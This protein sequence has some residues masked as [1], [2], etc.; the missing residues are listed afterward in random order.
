MKKLDEQNAKYIIRHLQ[1]NFGMSLSHDKELS[2]ISRILLVQ[3]NNSNEIM[4]PLY[5]WLNK[6]QFPLARHIHNHC[7]QAEVFFD[8]LFQEEANS[9]ESLYSYISENIKDKPHKILFPVHIN[10]AFQGLILFEKIDDKAWS[11]EEFSFLDA[12]CLVVANHVSSFEKLNLHAQSTVVLD[13]IMNQMHTSLYVTD[14]ETD[15]I[16]YMNKTMKEDFKLENPEGKVCWKI[17]QSGLNSRCESCPKHI[18]LTSN[19]PHPVHV[20]EEYNEVTK[21]TY[22][23]YDSLTQWTDGRIVH[24]QHSVDISEAKRLTHQVNFDSLT[25]AYSRRKGKEL[26]ADLLLQSKNENFSFCLCMIDVNDLK[27][28]NDT[29]GHLQGDHLLTSITQEIRNA[30]NSEDFLCR[31]SGDEFF[32]VFKGYTTEEAH[33]KM[34]QILMRLRKLK[35]FPE[36]HRDQEFCYGVVHSNNIQNESA[37]TLLGKADECLY[38]SK[39]AYHIHKSEFLLKNYGMQAKDLEP[40]EYNKELLYE[41]LVSSSDDYIYICNMNTNTFLYSQNMVDDFGLPA[42]IIKNAA[43]VWGLKVHEADKQKFLEANQEILDGR[44]LSHIVEYRAKNRNGKWVWLRCRGQVVTSKDGKDTI[45]AGFITNISKHSD[46]D[47]ISGL[48]NKFVFEQE[49]ERLFEMKNTNFALMLLNI[50]NFKNINALNSR[51]FGDGV[52]KLVAR[53]IHSLLNY[54]QTIYRLDGDEFGILCRNTS[55]DELAYLYKRIS[56]YFEYTIEFEHKRFFISL[57]AGCSIANVDAN[58]FQDLNKYA[59]Y[60]LHL[61]KLKGK[62]RIEFFS[63]DILYASQRHLQISNALRESIE[64]GFEGF[65]MEYQPILNKDGCIVG[66]E[67]LARF[68]YKKYGTIAPSEFIPILE[69]NGLIIPFG[70]WSFEETIKAYKDFSQFN[71]TL[72][73]NINLSIRQLENG[74]FVYFTKEIL[75]TYAVNNSHIIIEL[76]ESCV[77]EN[78]SQ[79]S[80]V[81]KDIRSCKMKVAMDDFGTGY[82]SLGL[83]K[84]LPFDCVKID[85]TFVQGIKQNAFDH[86]FIQLVIEMCKILNIKSLLEG[87]EQQDEYEISSKLDLDFYQGFYFGKPITKNAFIDLYLRLN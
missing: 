55:V 8:K 73:I 42:R 17:L 18:L 48:Y 24:F 66:A 41:A 33:F 32:V 12:F 3:T 29:Y 84:A 77:A 85:R 35:L 19:E 1:E 30:C 14:V 74:D 87:V 26:L 46:V 47:N 43:A 80:S 62:G 11:K 59:D 10:E 6:N 70:K 61:S 5:I 37:K 52:I 38:D 57:S 49:V 39:K 44:C 25:R 76:T 31:L 82:S 78:L 13:H 67:S 9:Y 72:D 4:L 58:N 71:P 60:A 51:T 68:K 23:N 63:D 75:D 65:S 50:D 2:K 40:F 81:L 21:K 34:K 54:Q 28:I 16:L 56:D 15:E 83:L 53:K 45:F 79:I 22:E 69:E 20:W 7:V 27:L 64:N 36:L 86:A